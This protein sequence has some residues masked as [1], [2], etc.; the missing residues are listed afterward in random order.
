M[1][2]TGASCAAADF[3]TSTDRPEAAAQRRS[4]ELVRPSGERGDLAELR[5]LADRGNQDAADV[6]AE[7]AQEQ[8][9]TLTARAVS[10]VDRCATGVRQVICNSGDQPVVNAAR[11]R[12]SA[13]PG[14]PEAQP[15]RPITPW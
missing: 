14:S 1:P 15:S 10:S 8:G 13:C 9:Q 2:A 12:S 6:L 3:T 7:L 4:D 5:R 11:K